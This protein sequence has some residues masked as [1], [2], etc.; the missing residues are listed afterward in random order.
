[1]YQDVKNYPLAASHL[2][3]ALQIAPKSAHYWQLLGDVKLL[4]KEYHAAKDYFGKASDLFPENPE[5]L[6][7]LAKINQKLGE[8]PIAIQCWQKAHQLDPDNPVYQTSIAQS[9][10]ARMEFDQA[11]HLA[12]QVLVNHPSNEKALLLIASAEMQSGKIKEAMNTFQ[13][14][15]NL[16]KDPIPFDL[17]EIDIIAQT[18][19]TKALQAAQEL[20]DT[21]PDDPEV[22][23]KLASYQI[24]AGLLDKAQS[25]LENSLAINESKPETLSILE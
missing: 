10:L 15:R 21:N 14:A 11:I 20:A 9:H 6:D 19:P 7:S 1:M 24:E 25:N 3:E 13:K 4:E 18:K 23:N 12:D 22:L 17:L 2:E 5:A 8:H 16:V